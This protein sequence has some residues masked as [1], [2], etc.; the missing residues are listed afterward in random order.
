MVKKL[1][2]LE[3]IM[4][5]SFLKTDKRKLKVEHTYHSLINV[6][7]DLD[8][9]ESQFEGGGKVRINSN[10]PLTKAIKK[11]KEFKD[12]PFTSIEVLNPTI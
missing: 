4:D 5:N 3:V 7:S 1:R 10:N 2:Q 11:R 12:V 6:D 8:E 9:E